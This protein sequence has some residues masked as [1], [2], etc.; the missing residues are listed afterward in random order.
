MIKN[1]FLIAFRNFIR[2][3]NYTLI[4]ILGLSI[5][6]TAC[7]IIFLLITYELSF[8]SFHSKYD[9]IYR[10]VRDIQ[11][12]PTQS[13][14][15]PYPFVKAFRNDFPDVPMVT[16]MH[17]QE[18]VVLA[19]GT[20]KQIV[21][22]VLFTDSLFFEIFD[23]EVLSGNPRV[24]LG[25]PGKIYLTE[26]LAR[27]L[28]RPGLT[29]LKI[30]RT[31]VE[32][33]GI[34]ADPPPNSHINFS[35]IVSMPTFNSEF[36]GGFDIN[37]WGLSARGFAYL[38]LPDEISPS[39]INTRLTD[40]VNKY[41]NEG[42]SKL[43]TLKLQPINDIHFDSNYDR[44]PGTTVNANAGQLTILGVLGLFILGI[45]CINFINLATASAET[46]SKEIGIRK[47]LGA[48]RGQLIS[49]Y[50]SETFIL[51]LLSIVVSLCAT[52]WLLQ[53]LNPFLGKSI[54]LHILSDW[55]LLLY[56]LGLIFITTLLA[57]YYPAIVLSKFNPV[58][59][60]K[61]RFLTY[62]R[63][64][65][66]VRRVL[67][68][69]QFLVAQVLL[70]GTL[71]VAEQMT[72]S[73]NK[74]LGFSK[75]AVINVPV[76]NTQPEKHQTLRAKLISDRNIEN[77][78]FGS[79]APISENDLSTE[80]FL[81]ERG[82]PGNKLSI[83]FVT[84]DQYYLDTYGLTLQAG[85]WFDERDE[86]AADYNLS[87]EDMRFSYV[88]NETAARSLGFANPED[89][90][91]KQ[92]TTG[93]G[94]FAAEVVGI[95]KD[96]HAA[97]LHAEIGP[98]V[99]TVLPVY[100]FD[101]GIK[102]NTNNLR[103]AIASIE[104]AYTEVYPEEFFEYEFLDDHLASLYQNDEK[105]FTLFKVFA[106]VSI[107]IGCL[108]LYGL[109]SFVANQKQKEVGIRKVMGASVFSIVFLF[110]KDFVKL[111]FVAFVLAVPLS[112]YVMNKWLDGFAYKI[113]ISWVI[114]II[115]FVVTAAIVLLTI[116]Y[117]SVMAARENPAI[118][119]RSE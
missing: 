114:F 29:T 75:Q 37:S 24:D 98:V 104:R 25:Q 3:K 61:G 2:K 23:F 84:V 111:V 16:Q 30:N 20:D 47:T 100:Y 6:T 13:S 102:V 31:D 10:V 80:Y 59:V 62:G 56:L 38:A 15:T 112:W 55:T 64:E 5:G 103:E 101:V 48:Q 99:F 12:P 21:K 46:K 97:S 66:S 39:S 41:Y 73:R 77:V 88:V 91:G 108:G 7:I 22:D 78:A 70:V 43:I 86:R 19:A 9:N 119:L 109:I 94:D 63:G 93:F 33:A 14:V 72:Y 53:W 110:T 71:V 113:D 85:R 69:F 17:F 36:I 27:K 18:E 4:N 67:V 74:P 82:D 117:R 49:Y 8:D 96:F 83:A 50:L 52:E 106:A 58:Q 105:T 90:I 116:S 44:N 32:I 51:S 26:S 42:E 118:T 40:F 76:P 65:V 95:G 1:Y 115:G 34:V 107:F 68:V 79:G 45:A 57:G 87:T 11:S 28:N 54:E 35:M 89:L 60:L 92:I 81:T